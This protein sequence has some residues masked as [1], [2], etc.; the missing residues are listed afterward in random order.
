MYGRMRDIGLILIVALITAAVYGFRLEKD[1]SPKV[2]RRFEV[3]KMT[4]NNVDTVFGEVER[5]SNSSLW[6]KCTEAGFR[7]LTGAKVELRQYVF[8]KLL[9]VPVVTNMWWFSSRFDDKYHLIE[10]SV[11]VLALG[12]MVT[13][14]HLRKILLNASSALPIPTNNLTELKRQSVQ[15]DRR[16]NPITPKCGAGPRPGRHFRNW[17]TTYLRVNKWNKSVAEYRQFLV[18]LVCRIYNKLH[19]KVPENE[20]REALKALLQEYGFSM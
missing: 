13:D 4:T 3:D 11:D 16:E 14:G 12:G 8:D 7:E 6:K 10:E 1:N 19:E 9:A 15:M 2:H 20:R 18:E 17:R 5:D